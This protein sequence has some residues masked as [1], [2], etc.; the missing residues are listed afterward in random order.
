MTDSPAA[1]NR[2]S[3]AWLDALLVYRQSRVAAML[4]L[5]FSAGLPF[6]LVFQTLSAWLRQAG[7]ERATIGMLAWVGI[8][9]S[10]KFLWA[11]IVDRVPLPLL[12]RWLGRRRSW[13]LL[14]QIGVALGLLNLARTDPAAALTP[15]VLGALLVAF[16]SAT[17]DIALDAWRIESAPPD[18][19]GAMAA[20]YQLGYR[21][22]ILVGTAGAFWVAAESGWG[23]AYSAMAALMA[24]G[25]VTTLLVR[26]PERP[27]ARDAERREQRVIDWLER[28]AHW[29]E[30]LRKAGARFIDA[31]VCPLVDFF[32]RYGVQLGILILV[33]ICT[34]RLT[35]FAMGVMSNPFY[36]DSG[37]TLKQIAAV[38]KGP[39]LVMSILGVILGGIVVARL[40]TTRALVLGS[41]LV[42]CSNLAYSALATVPAP[43]LVGLAL[44]NGADNL[45]IG[46]HGTSLIAFL[47]S[48]TSAR[49]TATQ[50]AL[51]SSLY[52][53]PG[54]FLM[55]T[56]GFV[57]DAIGYPRFFIYTAA[58]SVPGLVLLYWLVKRVPGRAAESAN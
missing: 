11:P 15:V 8:L 10:I 2:S 37:F 16:A 22:A 43:S 58:L 44:A 41:V 23:M 33:F 45:A 7:I 46:V 53:L 31:V 6:M 50:Y 27:A 42:I 24:I 47:S 28:N 48:L 38:V 51:F 34:Y 52:A 57:V 4:F 56:S 14:A 17:Q 49:Y 25:V 36:L 19:Q 54:K 13:M 21:V 32:A 5:G 12:T 1:A 29:P 3:R 39:G 35:D 40:G 20:A 30:P 55:G 18:L 26:E 9:Y